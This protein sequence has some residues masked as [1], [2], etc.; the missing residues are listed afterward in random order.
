MPVS[1]QRKEHPLYWP[2]GE[3]VNESRAG[4]PGDLLAPAF[5]LQ[6]F[7]H[8]TRKQFPEGI[9]DEHV[10][11]LKY[12]GDVKMASKLEIELANPDNI[13]SDSEYLI[14]GNEVEASFGYAF[15]TFFQGGR[16]QLVKSLPTFPRE[17]IPSFVAKGY[18]ARHNMALGKKIPKAIQKRKQKRWKTAPSR[19]PTMRDDQIVARIADH[20]KMAVDVDRTDGKQTRVRKK[21]KSP[22]EFIL[23]LAKING[24]H[25]WVDWDDTHRW[26]VHFRKIELRPSKYYTLTYKENGAGELLDASVELEATK[27]A[28]DVEVL[29]YD[30]SVRKVATTVLSEDT[31]LRTISAR[32]RLKGGNV[33]ALEE[34]GAR[35]RFSAFGRT[36]EIISDRPF[37]TK[38]QAKKF[39]ETWINERE[40]DFVI[41]TGTL[42]GIENIRERQIHK[43]VGLGKKYDGF[44]HFDQA[45]QFWQKGG[46]YETPFV[47]HRV[48]PDA[49]K[50]KRK[51]KVTVFDFEGAGAFED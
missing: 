20:Y 22:W 34:S 19:F 10:L 17:G 48:T 24:F 49:A 4:K 2:R 12:E 27:Q 42:I 36:M 3:Y 13:V 26:T 43:L 30:R 47:A 6:I 16:V 37:R 25:A 50:V 8:G 46:I 51:V 28:T 44:Y 33:L 35:V 9:L 18:D 41:C 39:A 38:K 23:R 7:K 14:E 32:S 5:R 45:T 11:S 40:A 1:V 29:S 15:Q 21:D 31:E